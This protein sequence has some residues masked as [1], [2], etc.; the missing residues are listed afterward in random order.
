MDTPHDNTNTNS[1]TEIDTEYPI[2]IVDSYVSTLLISLSNG[3]SKNLKGR[4]I[5]VLKIH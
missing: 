5:D 1:N 4:G 3:T 2:A